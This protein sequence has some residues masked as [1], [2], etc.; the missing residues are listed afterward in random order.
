MKR[1]LPNVYGGGQLFSYSALD[2]NA[3]MSCDFTGTLLPKEAGLRLEVSPQRRLSFGGK[4]TKAH[5][6][7]SDLL[8]LQTKA[9][10]VLAVFMDRHSIIGFSPVPPILS[11]GIILKYSNRM[12]SIGLKNAV[13]L[14]CE[15][16]GTGY[17]FAV[18]YAKRTSTALRRSAE[19]LKEDPNKFAA[20]RKAFYTKLDLPPKLPE[21]YASLYQ[22]AASVLKGN[23]YSPE[24]FLPC[25]WTTP[26]RVPHRKM[27]LWDSV[28]HAV[29]WSYLDTSVAEDAILALLSAQKPD[30]FISHE[31]SPHFCSKITQPPVIAWGI[32]KLYGRTGNKDFLRRTVKPVADFLTWIMKHRDDNA[33]GLPAW[34]V[35][36]DVNCRSDESGMDNSPRFDGAEAMDALDFSA[37]LANDCRCLS[38]LYD[39]LEQKEDADF[40][41]SKY[42]NLC[43]AINDLLWCPEDGLYY[44]RK[45][46]G[47]FEKTVSVACFLPL[48]AGVPDKEQAETLLK[49]LLNPDRFWS[50]LPL[51]SV[52][53]DDLRC[54]FDMWRGGVWI[55]INYLIAEGL[56]E[57]G[58]A[59]IAEELI[60]KTL[61]GIQKWQRRAGGLYEFYDPTDKVT[62]PGL[63]RKSVTQ[64][65]PDWRKHLHSV[66]D[67]GWTAA[68]TVAMLQEKFC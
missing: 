51:P 46:N 47:S 26:D 14:S 59:D 27:W 45:M 42:E 37:Y 18:S 48:F 29:G 61:A 54:N 32:K 35:T 64:K 41:Q 58:F 15:H 56:R 65:E 62:P 8:E 3:Q 67:F 31:I 12:L 22:K 52:A 23:V 50:P 2:G 9:G 60:Q 1:D 55:N 57:Y 66:C 53:L 39:I 40:W 38:A 7:T 20:L 36:S 5:A 30:G 33:N 49:T 24:G 19:V 34:K 28:F 16:E 11:G 43:K 4:V 10:A 21:A 17:K 6:V 13:S 25:R 63:P 68:L 44:D